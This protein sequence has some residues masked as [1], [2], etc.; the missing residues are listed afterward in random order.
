MTESMAN[1]DWFHAE[2]EILDQIFKTFVDMLPGIAATPARLLHDWAPRA[3]HFTNK[4]NACISRKTTLST[5]Y[6]T[7]VG[8]TDYTEMF[9]HV[10]AKAAI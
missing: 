7:Q 2:R 6:V 4:S 3:A 9:V 10:N 1:R 8:Y 5:I